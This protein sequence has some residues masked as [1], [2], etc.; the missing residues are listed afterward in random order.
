MFSGPA[1]VHPND[2]EAKAE[3]HHQGKTSCKVLL[4]RF[5]IECRKTKTKVITLPITKGTD[6]QVNQSKRKVITCS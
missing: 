5:S 1:H 3:A 6:S 4:E 2:E